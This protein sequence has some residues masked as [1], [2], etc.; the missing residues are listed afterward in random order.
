MKRYL[1]AT[2]AG[3]VMLITPA[4]ASASPIRYCGNWNAAGVVNITARKFTCHDARA[5]VRQYV[6]TGQGGSMD[7][8]VHYHNGYADVRLTQMGYV[9]R[10]QLAQD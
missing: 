10:F 3:I 7:K 2:L 6:R 1:L 4:T 9:V 8:S 5:F